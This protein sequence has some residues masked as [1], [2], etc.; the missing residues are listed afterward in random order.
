MIGAQS[1]KVGGGRNDSLF[2]P[3][4]TVIGL[5]A[6]T[7]EDVE[8]DG[9]KES[10]QGSPFSETQL[11]EPIILGVHGNWRNHRD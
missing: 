11:Q 5:I 7:L 2:D 10:S 9:K 6:A 4:G 3:G 8:R 1:K